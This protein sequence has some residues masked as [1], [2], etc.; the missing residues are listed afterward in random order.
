VIDQVDANLTSWVQDV[1]GPV[2]VSLHP[3]QLVETRS[4]ETGSGVHLYLIE[5]IEKPPPRGT[6]RPPLQL[7]LRYLVTTWAD[8][9]QEAHR[10]LGELVFAAMENAE[11][12]V[13]LEPAPAATWA[14]FG[15]PPQ[16][17]F[18]LR[19]PL[20]QERPQPAVRLVRAPLVMHV[21]PSA[22]LRGTVLGPDDVPLA[23]ATVELPSLLRSTRTDAQGRFHFANVPGE[24][25]LKLLRVK[26]K[27]RQLSVTLDQP[28]S[29]EEPLVIRFDLLD[30]RK[31]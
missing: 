17:S 24:S 2:S 3:P 28:P 29:D 6:E 4:L 22:I 30:E 18:V 21:A 9:P 27:G 1:L 12:E 31:S 23:G 14:A 15:V 20:Q 8:E 13:E 25:S 10:L 11:F 5:M 26:A 7:L 16:P 19:V